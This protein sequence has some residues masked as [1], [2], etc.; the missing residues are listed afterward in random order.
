MRSFVLAAAIAS[1]AGAANADIYNDNSGNHLDGGDLHDF[2]QSQGFD[3]LDI[4]SAEVTNDSTNLYIDLTV[5]ADLDATNWGKYALA[6]NNGSGSS[7]AGNGWGR[8]IDWSGQ[9]ITHW[10]ATWADGNGTEIGGQVWSYDS[11]WAET[12]AISGSDDS[13]HASGRQIFSIALADLGLSIGD[14]FTFDIVSTGGGNDPGVDHLSNSV[15]ATDEWGNTSAAGQFLSYT[16]VPAPGA[17]ALLGMGG[18][19][20]GRRRR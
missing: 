3:H 8:N 16:V 20:A 13:M 6:I 2:F 17:V 15:F 7:D 18:L 11:G 10:V 12:G 9:E 14:T 4:L 5:G 1:L 19:L